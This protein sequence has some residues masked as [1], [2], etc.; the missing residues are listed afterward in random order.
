VTHRTDW[1]PEAARVAIW[2][3][4]GGRCGLCWEQ[5]PALEAPGWEAH[6]RLKVR[7]M[8]R[9]SRWCPCDLVAL[10]ARCHTQGPVAVHDHPEAARAVGLILTAEQDPRDVTVDVQYPWQGAAYLDC[11]GVAVSTL[12][13]HPLVKPA[14]DPLPFH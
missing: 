4:Q 2:W 7:G 1:T 5:L 6:H 12:I 10:H 3:R 11:D 9:D 8:P 13:T 14:Q